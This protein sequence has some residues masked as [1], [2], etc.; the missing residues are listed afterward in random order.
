MILFQC[1]NTGVVSAIRKGSANE[2]LVMHLLRAL[3][4]FVAY[5]DIS[6]QIEHIPGIHNGIADQ[7]SRNYMQQFFFSNT[8]ESVGSNKLSLVSMMGTH[9]LLLSESEGKLSSDSS[10]VQWISAVTAIFQSK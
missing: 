9:S 8:S 6:I 3:W 10:V 4:F 5:F 7:L 2:P 1:D